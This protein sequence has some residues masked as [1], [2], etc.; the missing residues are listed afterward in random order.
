MMRIPS[1]EY[2]RI[3]GVLP[4]LCVDCL[5]FHEQKCLLIKRSRHPA[6]DQYWFPGGRV[7]KGEHIKNAAVRKA[8][9]EVNL[10][11]SFEKEISIEE[12]IFTRTGDMRVDVHTVNIC[13]QLSVAEVDSLLLDA[14]HEDYRW[15][16][17]EEAG[18]LHLHEAVRSPLMK[19]FGRAN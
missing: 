5:I 11:C 6:K 16:D 8:R 9:E 4:I 2:Q 7:F 14:A 13:C 18:N 3:I 12:T 15:V 17:L 19:L 10:H 1:N